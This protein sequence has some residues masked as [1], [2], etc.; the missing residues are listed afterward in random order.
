MA[1]TARRPR[2]I[3]GNGVEETVR[4][5]LAEATKE[6]A[7]DQL[8]ELPRVVIDGEAT[9][10]RAIATEGETTETYTSGQTLVL[11]EGDSIMEPTGMRQV[12]PATF[13]EKRAAKPS[14]RRWHQARW[15]TSWSS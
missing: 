3:G 4:Q 8:L 11:G 2:A 12:P 9:V 5:A 14:P 15:C 1:A 7:P 10:R 6:T 13:S